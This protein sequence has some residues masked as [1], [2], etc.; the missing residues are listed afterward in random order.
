MA[1]SI[2][3]DAHPQ[4]VDRAVHQWLELAGVQRPP[5]DALAVARALGITVAWDD[6]QGG[7]ARRVRLVHGGP[8]AAILIRHDPRPERVQWAVAHEL[9]EEA[10]ADVFHRLG[11]DPREAAPAARESLAN[12]FARA[13]LLPTCWFA[14]DAGRLDW[15]LMRLKRRY[16][17]ASHEL[18]ARRML[19][20]PVPAILTVFDQ[21]QI[22]WRHGAG[23]PR[24][25][26]LSP[27]ERACQR[28]V[29]RRG[30][31]HALVDAALRVQGWAI[32]QPP[33]Q[34]EILRTTPRDQCS[35]PLDPI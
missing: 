20:L 31:A 25:P 29:N 4:T 27:V 15:N 19:D 13:L 8:R 18:I 14:A 2:L 28:R 3:S 1:S 7:R 33:W 16:D 6:D 23:A 21:G 35:E 10:A 12:H 11:V 30:R 17:T 34:R 22:T 9:G 5:V 24:L 26:R 32:H